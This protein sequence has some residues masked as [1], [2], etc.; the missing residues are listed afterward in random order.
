MWMD[1]VELDLRNVDVNRRRTGALDGIKWASVIRE[2][3][4]KFKG[5]YC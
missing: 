2:T 1:G 3:R 5:L 4:A